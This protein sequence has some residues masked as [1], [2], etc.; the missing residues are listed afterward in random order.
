MKRAREAIIP[1]LPKSTGGLITASFALPDDFDPIRMR[2]EYSTE[3]TALFKVNEEHRPAWAN[4][5]ANE[6]LPDLTHVEFLFNDLL[7]NRVSYVWNTGSTEWRYAWRFGFSRGGAEILTQVCRPGQTTNPMELSHANADS[8]LFRPHL[9]RYFACHHAGR[10]GMWV[11]AISTAASTIT[12]TL[13]PTPATTQGQVI[14]YRW[15]DGS[16]ESVGNTPIATGQAAYDFNP[17]VSAYH[18]IEVVNPAVLTNISVLSRGT[19]GCWGHN[20]APYAVTNASS[21]E[22]CRIL[23]QSI[24]VRN[25]AAPLDAAGNITGLQPG[26]NRYWFSFATNSKQ[27]DPYPVIE[28]YAGVSASK[29]LATGIYGFKKPTEEADL[30]FQTPFTVENV[31]GS[32]TTQ[33]THA[34]TPILG[35]EYLVVAMQ[36][37]ALLGRQV[38]VRT[39]TSGEYETSNQFQIVKKPAAQP[40]D[41]RM[42]IEALASMQQWHCNPIHW[43]SILSTIGSVASVGGRILSLFGPKGAAIGGPMSVAGSILSDNLQ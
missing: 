28:N 19:C 12:I 15:Q 9:D 3:E 13:N 40:E 14:F 1:N 32:I 11:D 20:Y 38:I 22:S 7:R 21:I 25:I 26:K 6:Q 41:W 2:N 8:T 31:D 17:Q 42:G 24:L 35:V 16:W 43:K 34:Q 23:G 29:A 30:A 18:A 10:A 36:C 5:G 39:V 37:S 33:W 27:T 4:P